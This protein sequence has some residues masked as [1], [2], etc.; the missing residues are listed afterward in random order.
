MIESV[1]GKRS[2]DRRRAER[3]VR[4]HMDFAW[5]SMRRLGVDESEC[6]DGCQRVWLVVA[7][8]VRVMEKSKERSFIFSVVVRVASE[9]RRAAQR[10]RW[11]TLDCLDEETQSNSDP[12]GWCEQRRAKRLLDEQL[13]AMQWDNRVVFVLF[14][15]EGFSTPEIAELLEVSRGTVASRLRL[16]R[17]TF[18]RGLARYRLR[19]SGVRTLDGEEIVKARI[20]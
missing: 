13:A 8:K 10:R 9:M 5:R 15:I 11:E 1:G 7:R 17:E 6:D 12:E 3:L 18:R 4:E 19:S 14:E 20:S 16:A 2:E